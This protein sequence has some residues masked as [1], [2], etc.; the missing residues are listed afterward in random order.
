M[1]KF[2]KLY[3]ETTTPSLQKWGLLQKGRAVFRR[4]D[5]SRENYSLGGGPFGSVPPAGGPPGPRLP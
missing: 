3:L 1:K 5:R 2:R 4:E